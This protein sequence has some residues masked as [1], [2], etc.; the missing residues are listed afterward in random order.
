MSNGDILRV[1]FKM[2]FGRMRNIV[3]ALYHRIKY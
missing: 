1:R 3:K 2:I